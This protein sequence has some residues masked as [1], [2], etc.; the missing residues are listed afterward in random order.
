MRINLIRKWAV[1]IEATPKYVASSTRRDFPWANSHHLAGDL[2]S[3]VWKLKEAT[4]AGV[5]LGSGRLAT[6]STS[7]TSTSSSSPPDRGPRSDPVPG[8]G[9]PRTRRLELVS[10]VLLRNGVVALHLL[11]RLVLRELPTRARVLCVGVGT[12]VEIVALSDAFPEGT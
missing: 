6:D 3:S 11:I 7:S 10:A 2:G 1:K 5:L 4:P 12:G 9:L 8:G